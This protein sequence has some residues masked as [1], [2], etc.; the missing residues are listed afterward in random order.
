[1]EAQIR[2]RSGLAAKQ[3]VTVLNSPGT[4][5]SDYRGEIKVM[6]MNNSN[7]DIEIEN[8]DRIAQ[9][10]LL[11]YVKAKWK[12]VVQLPP[13]DRN[14]KG[15]GSTGVKRESTITSIAEN[16]TVENIKINTMKYG[17]K[18]QNT[19]LW[20]MKYGC[21][22]PSTLY[23]TQ[24]HVEGILE[25]LLSPRLFKC[26]YCEKAKMVKHS[27]GP[28]NKDKTLVPGQMYHLDLAF[29]S[30]PSNLREMIEKGAKQKDTIT[31]SKEGYIGF[32][33]IIDVATRY[34]WVFPI[35]KGSTNQTS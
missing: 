14:E 1:M 24:K 4:I 7:N 31:V 11:E 19:K 28:Q 9:M 16:E 34:L 33:T 10:V 22:A 18:V 6:L 13:T 29:V 35:K 32:L 2:S 3:G 15:F 23:Q 8:G 21:S 5:D 26:P 17:E 12:Q 27:G 30:G 20:H 25:V